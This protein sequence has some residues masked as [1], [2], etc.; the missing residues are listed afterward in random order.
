[1]KENLELALGMFL[2]VGINL[3]VFAA[4]VWLTVSIVKAVW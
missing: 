4:A 2:L 3:A 1:L